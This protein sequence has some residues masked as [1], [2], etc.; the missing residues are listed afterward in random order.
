METNQGNTSKDF[1]GTILGATLGSVWGS[2]TGMIVVI[3]VAIGLF[4]L[5]SYA[6][7]SAISIL[8]EEMVVGLTKF[9]VS[10]I[11]AY[12]VVFWVGICL[13]ITIF[14]GRRRTNVI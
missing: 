8:S 5:L 9:I 13:I 1:V 14:L 2:L 7:I 11:L 10:D 12:I 6:P 3:P 4:W